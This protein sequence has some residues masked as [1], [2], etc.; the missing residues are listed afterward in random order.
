MNEDIGLEVIKLLLQQAWADG[1]L[2]DAEAR[3]I[4]TVAGRVCPS[5][6]P[7]VERWL[8]NTDPL[9]MPNVAAVAP[10]KDD[11]MRALANVTIADGVVHPEEQRILHLIAELLDA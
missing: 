11:V 7:T 6:A 1:T 2:A 9:P 5:H 3:Y 4:R 10:V 8:N